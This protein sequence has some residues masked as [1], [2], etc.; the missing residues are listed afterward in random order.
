MANNWG[1]CVGVIALSKAT[2]LHI[3]RDAEMD[4][5]KFL[6]ISKY[7]KTASYSGPA[8]GGA[9]LISNEKLAE[10]K[11]AIDKAVLGQ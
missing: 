3:N 1:Q 9:L 11:Q 8:K 2:E 4:G 7:V 6:V 10:L 5:K